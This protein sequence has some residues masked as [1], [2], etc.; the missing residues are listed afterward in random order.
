[1]PLPSSQ[2]IQGILEELCSEDDWG[3]WELWWNI[4]AEVSPNEIPVLKS[5]FLDVVGNM[6]ATGKLIAKR[7]NADGQ[8]IPTSYDQE[9]YLTRSIQNAIRTQIR[10]SGLEVNER[11]RALR[12]LRGNS[13]K[14]QRA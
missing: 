9:S 14:I 2:E 6:V 13:E 7:Q 1:M 10:F 5:Q 12:V 8:C 3:S 11:L 4:A